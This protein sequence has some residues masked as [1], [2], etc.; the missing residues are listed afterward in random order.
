MLRNACQARA[1]GPFISGFTSIL[2]HDK[3]LHKGSKVFYSFSYFTLHYLL[4][5][6]QLKK[7]YKNLHT[8]KHV[9]SLSSVINS[10]FN[11]NKLQ[12]IQTAA[13]ITVP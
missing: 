6:I 5:I 8:K 7:Q 10:S 2:E 3:M 1:E 11:L 9:H 13:C 12:A 4:L